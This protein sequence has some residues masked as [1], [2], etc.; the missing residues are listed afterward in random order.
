MMGNTHNKALTTVFIIVLAACSAMFVASSIAI[1]VARGA[2]HSYKK[3]GCEIT[4]KT[5]YS[6]YVNLK[7]EIENRNSSEI[8][9]LRIK[10]KVYSASSF[11]GSF[12]VTFNNNINAKSIET[13]SVTVDQYTDVYWSLK[14][15][16]YSSLTFKHY[17]EDIRFY[18]GTYKY[19]LDYQMSGIYK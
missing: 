19:D 11:Y 15:Y 8:T 7:Y 17:L 10:T 16:S 2:R 3:V 5:N 9:Y 4:S 14:D 13:F 12:E 6:S 1:P 18:D